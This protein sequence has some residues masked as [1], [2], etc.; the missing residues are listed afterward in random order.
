V[1]SSQLNPLLGALHED[2]QASPSALGAAIQSAAPW[3]TAYS[4]PIQPRWKERG[5]APRE[6]AATSQQGVVVQFPFVDRIRAL[7]K[8][9]LIRDAQILL[10]VAGDSV[11]QDS[12]IRKALAPPRVRRVPRNDSDRSSEFHWLATKSL[13]YRG[14]WVALVGDELVA[15]TDTLKELLASVET[16][17][18]SG[19]PLVHHL[20]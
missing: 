10:E 16:L 1:N 2:P 19:P 11:P 17:A 15:Q 14:K 12:K 6:I 8:L 5:A 7:L 13:P 20:N 3:S 4:A 9:G 18:L